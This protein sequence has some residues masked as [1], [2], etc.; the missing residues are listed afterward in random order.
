VHLAADLDGGRAVILLGA[1]LLALFVLDAPW[2]V[3]AVIGGV[4]VE[5]AESLFWVRW[6]QQ[7]RARVGAETLIGQTARVL[8]TTQVQV[9]GEIWRARSTGAAPLEPGGEVRILA[10]ED[11]TLVVEPA[12]P[13]S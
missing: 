3:A 2:S 7:R 4:V 9:K 11:L 13:A 1:V 5:V 6:S 8:T 10:L 12:P